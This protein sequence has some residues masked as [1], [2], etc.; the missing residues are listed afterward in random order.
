[1]AIESKVETLE[2]ELKLMKGEVKEALTGVR[3]FLLNLKFPLPDAGISLDGDGSLAIKGGL[4]LNSNDGA[5]RAL[6]QLPE[7][8]ARNRAPSE[9]VNQNR[10][11]APAPEREPP[12]RSE[13]VSI[14]REVPQYQS[15]EPPVA[16][17]R[18]SEEPKAD[19]KPV[20]QALSPVK[21]DTRPAEN[22]ANNSQSRN[23]EEETMK[24]DAV[25]RVPPVNLLAN[26]IRWVSVARNEFGTE[27]LRTFLEVYAI[28]DNLSSEMKEVILHLAD[29]AVQ[30]SGSDD[31]C[32]DT[33]SRLMLELHG[34]L[35]GGGTPL[36]PEGKF[37]QDEPEKKELAAVE[38]SVAVPIE[39]K[40]ERGVRL[41]LIVPAG[42]GGDK[43]FNI[44]EFS[45]SLD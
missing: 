39:N 17:A 32:A 34:I 5:A 24:E 41:K 31:A 4:E 1:M 3:D 23:Q 6:A 42:N 43:E 2:G 8:S 14:I 21:I 18:K 33:W 36:K 35:S 44:D 9:P 16:P 37:W 19:A 28:S 12:A 25:T 45:V 40:E 11:Y 29:V 22:R 13:P 38:E 15:L 10:A 20:N 26:L 30:T 27:C 7:G